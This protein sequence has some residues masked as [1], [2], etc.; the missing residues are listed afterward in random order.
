MY[1]YRKCKYL[2]STLFHVYAHTSTSH[3]PLCTS[4]LISPPRLQVS[5]EARWSA[6]APGSVLHS[7]QT[8]AETE[9][10]TMLFTFRFKILFHTQQSISSTFDSICVVTHTH[11][12]FHALGGSSEHTC[13]TLGSLSHGTC[14]AV[15]GFG[16]S[17]KGASVV[18]LV[19]LGIK[20]AT[21]RSQAAPKL[22]MKVVGRFSVTW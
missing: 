5:E 7:Q 21:F 6:V 17:L 22:T 10:T 16:V 20:L 18:T 14:G 3:L 4:S 8:Y 15:R 13:L 1:H 12:R 11:T 2:P 9:N 19:T